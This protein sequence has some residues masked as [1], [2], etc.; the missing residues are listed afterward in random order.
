MFY[1]FYRMLLSNGLES[2][3]GLAVA[4]TTGRSRKGMAGL[5]V[6]FCRKQ[7]HK[8]LNFHL[9]PVGK[10]SGEGEEGGQEQ[11]DRESK[12]QRRWAGELCSPIHL[13]QK[14]RR[15]WN[16][17]ETIQTKAVDP[18]VERSNGIPERP[19]RHPQRHRKLGMVVHVYTLRIWKTE[20]RQ[21]GS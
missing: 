16:E 7:K 1:R 6:W 3:V 19:G 18:L 15:S 10:G 2:Q 11:R 20:E 9:A 14:G 12:R 5:S 21:A 13:G 8:P 17:L 4:G